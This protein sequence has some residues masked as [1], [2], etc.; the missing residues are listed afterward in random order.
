MFNEQSP[1]SDSSGVPSP[2]IDP[3]DIAGKTSEEI[4]QHAK[5][6]GLLPKGP[7]P[8]AGRGGYIDPQ[9]G[10]QRLLCHVNC[11][12]PHAHVNDAEG[13]RLD[14][15]GNHTERDSPEAHLPIN[16]KE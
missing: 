15:N 3:R 7:D 16:V 4:D 12:S 13:R 8:M 11:A 2:V 14:I 1:S 9:I 10:E 5:E 6:K